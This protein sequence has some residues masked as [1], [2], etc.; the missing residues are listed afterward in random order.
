MKCLCYMLCIFAATVFIGCKDVKVP[1]MDRVDVSDKDPKN[2]NATIMPEVI[3]PPEAKAKARKYVADS[4]YIDLDLK[5]LTPRIIENGVLSLGEDTVAMLLA[6]TYRFQSHL[7]VNEGL[8]VLKV[9]SGEEI[10]LS[11]RLFEAMKDDIAQ[12]NKQISE[13]K[14][15]GEDVNLS[16]I[17]ADYLES[18]LS[19]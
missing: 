8:Y 11:E 15:K 19:Q 4:T 17:S 13:W 1:P 3:I 14:E 18:L 16:E 9:A 5:A 2:N 12:A 10:Q 6:A 7:K